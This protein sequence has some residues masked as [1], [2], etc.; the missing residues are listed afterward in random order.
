MKFVE[1]GQIAGTRITKDGYLVADVR[2]AR[3]GIQEYLGSELG[4]DMDRVRVYRP[5]SAVFSK[6]SLAT[7]VGKPATDDHPPE[8]VNADNWKDFAVGSIGNEVLRDGEFI[9]VPLTLMDAAVIKKVQAGKREI[10][11]GYEMALDFTPGTTPDGQAYDAVM[12]NLKMNHLAVVHRGRAGAQARIGDT[13][14]ASPLTN[15]GNNAMTTKFVVVDGLQVETTEAG[16]KAIEKLQNDK[17]AA[18]DAAKAAADAEKAKHDT[19]IADKDRVIAQKD[20]DLAAKDAKLKE[21]EGQV[22]D[23]AALDARVAERATLIA[24][25]TV[26]AK[27]ADFK[28]KSDRDIKRIALQAA[29]GEDFAKDKSDAYVDA[30]FDLLKVPEDAVRTA[31]QSKDRKVEFSADNGQGAYE[32]RLGDAWKEG[33]K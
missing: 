31:L 23:D 15:D 20:A 16:A 32:K 22:L 29:H 6:D 5:E 14:G 4:V 21:L 8:A 33:N 1:D 30:A 18:I 11:M 28:G 24:K 19:A 2:C 9:R 25:A 7:F 17:Q 3:T 13:W 10:S 26:V 12:S 27:D